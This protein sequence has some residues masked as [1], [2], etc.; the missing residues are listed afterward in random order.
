MEFRSSRRHKLTPTKEWAVKMIVD[1]ISRKLFVDNRIVRY[2]RIW[3]LNYLTPILKSVYSTHKQTSE[4]LTAST[5]QLLNRILQKQLHKAFSKWQLKYQMSKVNNLSD[6]YLTGALKL[7]AVLLNIDS[8]TLIQKYFSSFFKPY[9]RK[10]PLKL[11]KALK[12]WKEKT[13]N[14]LLTES[15]KEQGVIRIV[16]SLNKKVTPVIHFGLSQV[17]LRGKNLLAVRTMT[18]VLTKNIQNHF[19]VC[20][21]KLRCLKPF[22]K[23]KNWNSR[24]KQTRL[25]TLQKVTSFYKLNR[26]LNKPL[27]LRAKYA[28]KLRFFLRWKKESP[29]DTLEKS[30]HLYSM[31]PSEHLKDFA[32]VFFFRTL[33]KQL[34]LN[35]LKALSTWKDVPS[36][37]TIKKHSEFQIDKNIISNQATV[38]SSLESQ[39]SKRTQE[40]LLCK[41][42]RLLRRLGFLVTRNMKKHLSKWY[43]CALNMRQNT[44]SK[45]V[46]FEYIRFL[47]DQLGL[48]SN[49][50][51]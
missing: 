46:L 13:I 45:D 40:N 15:R 33:K 48:E 12:L 43:R 36:L 29:L 49:L 39:I 17:L 30:I 10:K 44:K 41:K 20:F 51:A 35:L 23:V 38:L 6:Q 4:K 19:H 42:K 1:T 8:K 22:T 9:S 24:E 32:L 11:V 31:A 5:F 47:E 14:S 37:A 7:V 25:S 18:L 3:Q 34:K 28:K 50:P 16:H 27:N 26:I 21:A 2:F